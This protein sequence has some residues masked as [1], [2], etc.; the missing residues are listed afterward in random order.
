MPVKSI[1]SLIN[2][3]A[4]YFAVTLL[5]FAVNHYKLRVIRVKYV[6]VFI[7][8]KEKFVILKLIWNL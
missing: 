7:A 5:I 3:A 1:I 4:K 8:N 6:C 2:E